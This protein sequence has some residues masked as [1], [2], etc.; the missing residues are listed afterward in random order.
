[1][2]ETNR[3]AAEIK[4]Q[5]SVGVFSEFPSSLLIPSRLWSDFAA[6][7][8]ES[9]GHT[10][11]LLRRLV[12]SYR[13]SFFSGEFSQSGSTR[14]V[15]QRSCQHL[16]K[17]TFR[18]ENAVWLE[19]GQMAAYLG[20]S[21]CLLFT[22]LLE[23]AARDGFGD[24]VGTPTEEPA[25]FDLERPLRILFEESLMPGRREGQRK[26][27]LIPYAYEQLPFYIRYEALN[28]LRI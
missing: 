6:G 15:Y 9:N 8:S 16:V 27:A 21:R 1:M 13:A 25:R 23:A 14:R 7:R 10:G 22:L 28:R 12:H 4:T 3:Y 24:P 11:V 20:V 19:F 5:F 18:V 17:V 26:A 2:F